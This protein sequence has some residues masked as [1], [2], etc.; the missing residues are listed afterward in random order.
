MEVFRLLGS[1]FVDNDKANKSIDATDK[2]GKGL[3]GTL[4]SMAGTAAKVG[5]GIAIGV[6]VAATAVVG[7]A[8]KTASAADNV[9]KMS[10]KLGLSRQ[11]FQEWDFIAS[12]SGTSINS[13]QAGMRG[14]TTLLEDMSKGGNKS[15]DVF[16]RLG[17]SMDDVAGMSRE[18]AFEAIVTSLQGIPDE[19]ERARLANLAFGRSGQELMPLING[20]AG[21]IDEMKEKAHELGLVMGDE[22]IDAGVAFTDTLDQLKRTIGATLN[23]ALAPLLPILNE[24]FQELVQLIPPL[25]GFI[26]PLAERLIPVIQRIIDALLPVFIS[27]LNAVTPILD[28]LIDLFVELLDTVLLPLIEMLIPL[29]EMLIPVLIDLLEMLIPAIMPLIEVLMEILV[30]VLPPLIEILQKV[31]DK[32]IPLLGKAFELVAE[33]IEAYMAV[34]LAVVQTVMSILTGDWEGAWQGIRNIFSTYIEYIK[35]ILGVFKNVFGSIWNSV[36]TNAS[37][38]FN[39]IFGGIVTGIKGHI[40]KI[41]DNINGMIKAVVGGIKRVGDV[42]SKIPGVNIATVSAPQIPKLATGTNYV[43]KDMIAMLHEGE[44]VVPKKYNPSAANGVT[45][46]RGAFEGAIITD[47]YGVDRLMERIMQRYRLVVES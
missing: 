15:A 22:A 38:M 5:A 40:N 28:P 31:T 21:S 34:I 45:F 30:T 8:T 44:A 43:P 42:I 47:D 26:R 10:Q 7:L 2:K 4:G 1:I 11:A 23:E 24:V 36:W 19:A 33:L 9:D 13:M 20:A 29:V 18:Q 37:D 35:K 46:G 6:G 16:G 14:V 17:L 12:Q 32:V 25:M 27:L 3:A 41:I 39:K